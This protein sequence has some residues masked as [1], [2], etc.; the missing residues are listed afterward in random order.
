MNEAAFDFLRSEAGQQMLAATAVIP[1]TPHNHLAIISRLRQQIAPEWA[2]AVV[3]TVLLRQ[4][5]TTK[6]SRAE[7]MYFTRPALEQASGETIAA[8]RAQRFAQAGHQRMADCG[9]GIGGDSLALAQVGE[10]WGVEQDSVRLA[11]AAENVRVYGQGERFHPHLADLRA[12][13]S[14]P[15]DALFFDPARRDGNG[16]RFFSVAQ[17]EPP[18]SWL[19]QWQGKVKGTAVKISPGVDYAELPPT[20]EVEFISVAGEV[21]EGVLW[22]GDLHSGVLRRATLL[23]EGI[24][25]VHQPDL[26]P[27]LVT[28][29]QAYLIEPDKAVIRAHLVEELAVA[30]DCTKIDKD[31]AYLT[32]NAPQETP[33]ATCFMVEDFFPFQL[34]RLRHYLRERRIGSVTIKKRGSPLEPDTLARELRLEGPE[35]RVLFLT[36]TG[37]TAVVLIG[38]KWQAKQNR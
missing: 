1:I 19:D 22:G 20:A 21:K 4:Q 26:A 11:M 24:T 13:S 32:A 29:P 33:F 2:Q 35:H 30:L 7:Q 5:A 18:L 38:Q 28:S 36:Q 37:G 8:Y 16:R 31:I 23:P 6:F 25:L 9:C 27:V 14:L 34:K 3:E 15:V 17:Y 10:V 12:L